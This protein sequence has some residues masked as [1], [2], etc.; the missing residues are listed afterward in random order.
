MYVS[1]DKLLE[2][3]HNLFRVNVKSNLELHWGN[4]WAEHL[5]HEV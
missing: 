3:G 2:I 5:Q 1:A 4:L